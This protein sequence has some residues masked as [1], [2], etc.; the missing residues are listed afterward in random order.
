MSDRTIEDIVHGLQVLPAT[1]R[2][3]LAHGARL[4]TLT[5]AAVK[6]VAAGHNH[7]CRIALRCTNPNATCDCGHDELAKACGKGTEG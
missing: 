2:A 3:L 7:G 6:R 5:A 1:R 4:S